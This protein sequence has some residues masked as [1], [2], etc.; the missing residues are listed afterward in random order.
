MTGATN[1][2]ISFFLRSKKPFII[3]EIIDAMRS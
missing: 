3:N 1:D 2:Y